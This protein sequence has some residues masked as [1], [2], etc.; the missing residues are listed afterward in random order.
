MADFHH[1]NLRLE[2]LI[3]LSDSRNRRRCSSPPPATSKTQP[4]HLASSKHP[5]FPRLRSHLHSFLRCPG[6]LLIRYLHAFPLQ[7]SAGSV[8]HL[9]GQPSLSAATSTTFMTRT[10]PIAHRPVQHPLCGI[11]LYLVGLAVLHFKY[12][13]LRPPSSSSPTDDFH[14]DLPTT[15]LAR[16]LHQGLSPHWR[17]PMHTALMDF[18]TNVPAEPTTHRR[19]QVSRWLQTWLISSSVLADSSWAQLLPHTQRA[20]TERAAEMWATRSRRMVTSIFT[21][22]DLPMI[23]NPI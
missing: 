7:A 11:L 6:Q 17:F 19:V 14:L 13:Y 23:E 8:I 1:T 5:P 18:I 10:S 15:H 4:H 3:L 9:Y 22:E 12:P 20:S 16:R 2:C 21:G